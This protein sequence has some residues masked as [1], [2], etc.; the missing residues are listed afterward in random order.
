VEHD[1]ENTHALVFCPRFFA[2]IGG[3]SVYILVLN[4]GALG[5]LRSSDSRVEGWKY[6]M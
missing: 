5:R 6:P 1:S 4:I 3:T 2:D